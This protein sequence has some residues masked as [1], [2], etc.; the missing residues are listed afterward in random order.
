MIIDNVV[1][2]PTW[3]NGWER[4]FEMA[5]SVATTRSGAVYVVQR[6]PYPKRVFTIPYESM[7]AVAANSPNAPS[8]QQFTSFWML[9]GGTARGFLLWDLFDCYL[10]GLQIGTGTG[11]LATFQ[12]VQPFSD[13]VNSFDR[14]IYHP[15]PSPYYV[16]QNPPSSWSSGITYGAGEYVLGSDS[17]V[18]YCLVSSSLNQNPVSTSGFWAESNGTYIPSWIQGSCGGYSVAPFSVWVDGVLQTEGT[19][20][21]VNYSTGMVTFLSGHIP[22]SGAPITATFCYFT[23]VMF[24]EET[25]GVTM[26][27]LFGKASVKLKEV[28]YS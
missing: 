26:N 10:N 11:S 19:A 20:Y 18:Y 21:T 23:P 4:D 7:A 25:E 9:R 5:N 13:G 3:A 22:G 14:T 6:W 12:L 27:S 1:F 2:F 17:N 24:T 16:S 15:A 8:V 28:F